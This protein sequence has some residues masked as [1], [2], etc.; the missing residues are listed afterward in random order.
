[1]NK[2]DQN[3]IF[4]TF[5]IIFFYPLGIPYM[6]Y[7][8]AYSEKVRWIITLSFIGAIVLGLSAIV[9]MTSGPDYTM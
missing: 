2:T 9:F 7:S 1:M 8:G 6:W 5:F 4:T 3:N